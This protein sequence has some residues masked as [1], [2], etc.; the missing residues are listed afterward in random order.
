MSTEFDPQLVQIVEAVESHTLS[1][2]QALAEI[3][4]AIARAEADALPEWI[5]RQYLSEVAMQLQSLTHEAKLI[6]AI[7]AQ[8]LSFAQ[9]IDA[10]GHFPQGL[11]DL[12]QQAKA[13]AHI[14]RQLIQ[15]EVNHEVERREALITIQVDQRVQQALPLALEQLERS[16]QLEAQRTQLFSQRLQRRQA[17]LR[18]VTTAPL[19]WIFWLLRQAQGTTLEYGIFWGLLAC[20]LWLGMFIGANQAPFV[21]CPHATSLCY[22]L[23]WDKQKV[24]LP[25]AQ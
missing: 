2:Q 4:S 25:H 7:N 22:L 11:E 10:E 20:S 15:R 1:V 17:F 3:T 9:P 24:I 13:L 16:V 6:E 18:W 19:G 8:V 14:C 12:H 5:A 21:A 23:R